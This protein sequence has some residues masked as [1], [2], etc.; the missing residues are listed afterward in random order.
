MIEAQPIVETT[1]ENLVAKVREMHEQCYRLVQIGATPCKELVEVN[2]S[3]DRDG[4]FTTLRV[5]V[6]SVGASL[7]SVSEVYWCAFIYENELHDLF[8]IQVT[9]NAVDYKGEFYRLSV[10]FPYAPTITPVPAG[11]T[12]ASEAAAAASN[13]PPSSA[14]AAS[15]PATTLTPAPAQ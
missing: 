6:P 9:G 4:R 1:P 3:F 14:P 10:P 13:T 12:P 5:R 8:K 11:A 7:P 2:Y 15:A